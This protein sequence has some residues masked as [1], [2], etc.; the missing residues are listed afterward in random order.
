MLNIQIISTIIGIFAGIGLLVGGCGYAYSSWKNGS[1]RYKDETIT[2]LKNVNEQKDII[3][4]KLNEEKSLLI[5]SHQ[6]QITIMQKQIT[7]LEVRLEEQGKKLT[8]YAAILEN[9]DPKTL[10]MLAA[11]KDGIDTLNQ[12]NIKSEKA[13]FTAAKKVIADN[14]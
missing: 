12:H 1:S 2:D 4:K 3:I 6:Q 5:T 7:E 11:I 10:S 13:L 8:E 14:K 9:R